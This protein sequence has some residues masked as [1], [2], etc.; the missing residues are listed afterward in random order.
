MRSVQANWLFGIDAFQALLVAKKVLEHSLGLL[1]FFFLAGQFGDVFG[2]GN[3]TVKRLDGD[4][5]DRLV[6]GLFVRR[7]DQG[8]GGG[9]QQQAGQGKDSRPHEQAPTSGAKESGCGGRRAIGG[10]HKTYP[11]Y[12]QKIQRTD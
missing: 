9:Q 6:G 1:G 11:L 4:D 8:R 3:Q 5:E 12:S 7:S 2:V 10:P